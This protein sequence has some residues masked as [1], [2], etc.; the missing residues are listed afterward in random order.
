MNNPSIRRNKTTSATPTN[1]ESPNSDIAPSEDPALA[2]VEV[3]A[4]EVPELTEQEQSVDA[5]R[6]VVD[7][8]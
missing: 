8:A 1:S 7:I 5:K 6:L 2:I 4:V 3:P